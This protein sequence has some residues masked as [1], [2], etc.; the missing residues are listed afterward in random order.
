MSN[1]LQVPAA[2][3]VPLRVGIPPEESPIWKMAVGQ[4]GRASVYLSQLT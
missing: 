3:A 4:D 1:F 2:E